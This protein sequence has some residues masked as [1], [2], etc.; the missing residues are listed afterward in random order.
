MPPEEKAR[1]ISDKAGLC[2]MEPLSEIVLQLTADGVASVCKVSGI[3]LTILGSDLHAAEL[4]AYRSFRGTL[5]LSIHRS[6]LP[7]STSLPLTVKHSFLLSVSRISL[8]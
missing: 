5:F 7:A 4:G 8:C 3:D 2:A 6:I 1:L